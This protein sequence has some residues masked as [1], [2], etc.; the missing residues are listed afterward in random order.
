MFGKANREN[1]EGNIDTTRS[2]SASRE[3]TEVPHLSEV[4][5]LVVEHLVISALFMKTRMLSG[6]AGRNQTRF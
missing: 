5:H 3:A 2:G 6:I 4:P 1:S